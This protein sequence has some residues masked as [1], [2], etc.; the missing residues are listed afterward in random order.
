MNRILD[1]GNLTPTEDQL[2]ARIWARLWNNYP[3]LR[4]LCWHVPNQGSSLKEGIRLQAMG[5]LPGVWDLHMFIKGQFHIWE[6]KTGTNQLTK[7]RVDRKGRKHYGQ[8]EWGELMAANGAIRHISRT[9]ED[10]FQQLEE[11]LRMLEYKK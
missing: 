3:N 1:G 5:V 6:I 8:K 9:E 4:R 2:Q 11:M 7:D 10:F